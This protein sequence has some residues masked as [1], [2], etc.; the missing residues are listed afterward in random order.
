MKARDVKQRLDIQ[1]RIDTKVYRRQ[2]LVV[3]V[4]D[5]L[6]KIGIFRFLHLLGIV[7]P[8]CID[9]V[10]AVAVQVDGG[11]LQSCCIS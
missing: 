5:E 10:Y 1:R 11:I 7:E 4:R 3:H 9:G 6:V 8:D 2:R